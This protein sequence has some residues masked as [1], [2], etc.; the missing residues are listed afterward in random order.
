MDIVVI[1]QQ[2]MLKGLWEG[3]KK[4]EGIKDNRERGNVIWK[5]AFSVAVME[6]TSLSLQR[7]GQIL[8]KNHATILH[9]KK[10]HQPNYTYDSKYRLC[11]EQI[12]DAIAEIVDEYDV[13]V[14]R[15][16]RSRSTIINPSLDKLEEEWERKLQRLQRKANEQYAELEKRYNAVSKALKQQT[17]RADELNTE[18]LRLKNLL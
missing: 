12:S 15:A 11:Y 5:H 8:G 13:E 1:D 3:I 9:A 7:I 6:Q 18:C 17:K 10:Q 16:M 2:M 14:K 4:Q